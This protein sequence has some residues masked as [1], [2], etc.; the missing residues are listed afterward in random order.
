M[1]K[2]TQKEEI[3]R[4]SEQVERLTGLVVSQQNQPEPAS[5]SLLSRPTESMVG[6]NETATALAAAQAKAQVEARFLVAI[7]RTRSIDAA[8]VALLN[9][10]RRHNFAEV[11]TFN[12]P[13]G[14][15]HNA[16]GP[17][18]R[19]AESA[20]R[21]WTNLDIDARTIYDSA[22]K[23]IIA[24]KV[25]D[26]ES[27]VTYTVEIAVNKTVERRKLKAGQVALASRTNSTGQTVYLVEATEDDLLAKGNALISKAIRTS[28]IRHLPGDL[29][30][31]G[32]R[33][34]AQTLRNR[35]SR[36]PDAS[37]KRIVD[38]FA[39]LNVPVAELSDL[40][41]HDIGSAS[42]TEMEY[43]RGVYAAIKEGHTTWGEVL[44]LVRD[45]RG[46]KSA[47]NG[48]VAQIKQAVAG[49][50]KASNGETKGPNG[51]TEGPNGETKGPNGEIEE[52]SSVQTSENG[53]F[54]EITTDIGIPGAKLV[55]CVGPVEI[56]F[57]DNKDH[58]PTNG[59]VPID[60]EPT[61]A[62]LGIEQPVQQSP[63]HSPDGE[64]QK[65]IKCGSQ[66]IFVKSKDPSKI[67]DHFY[68]KNCGNA[69]RV[70]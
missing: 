57:P 22:E 29:V 38:S 14:G 61:D 64:V 52:E 25:T 18:I 43:L 59:E 2:T 12:R 67:S 26:L 60:Q 35:D 5:V 50:A 69:Q 45:E 48:R 39:S 16:M 28:I 7:N 65:C 10:C 58:V 17:S 66:M 3:S 19:F 55:T 51:E 36:D 32:Q 62:D 21:A 24:V 37:R 34:C 8:R 44:S 6:L 31:E 53:K 68:C 33:V 54:K 15:G 30:D 9:D 11:A 27:N 41:N 1:P 4:L 70:E 20:A 40:L 42:P 63:I 47:E 13:V 46:G 49:K 56:S 23:R